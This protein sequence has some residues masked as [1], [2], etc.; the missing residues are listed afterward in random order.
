[1]ALIR[2]FICIELDREIAIKIRDYQYYIKTFGRGV[3]WVK[4]E[5]IHLTLKFLGDVEEANIASIAE[6]LKA[7]AQD[8]APFKIKLA[9]SGAFPNFKRPRIYWIGVEES[10]GALEKL[11]D[12]IDSELEKEGFERERRKFSPHLTL[13]RIKFIQEV[14]KI[15]TE[16][17]RTNFEDEEFLSR[18][19]VIMK[20]ELQ[21]GG[22]VYAP[23]FKIPFKANG[24]T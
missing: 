20:S 10:T 11:H 4:P 23:L 16:L 7:I 15:S 2:A 22:A 18:E 8:F 12:L 17:Q 13:G 6:R 1:M 14:E 24:S 19:I 3:R 21:P 9:G 5:G